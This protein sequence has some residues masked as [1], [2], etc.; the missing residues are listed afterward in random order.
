MIMEQDMSLLEV[1]ICGLAP[2]GGA[3]LGVKI[4]QALELYNPG[5]EINAGDYIR[6]IPYAGTGAI[7]G[8]AAVVT[9]YA[10]YHSITDSE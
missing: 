9:L 2:V 1:L 3:F 8:L 5:M 4:A 7:I 6:A 10:I